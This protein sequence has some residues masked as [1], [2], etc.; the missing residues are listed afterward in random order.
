M[1]IKVITS[2]T[3]IPIDVNFKVSAGPGAGKTHWLIN[4]IKSVLKDSEKLILGRKIA[5]IT[6]TNIGVDTI[7]SRLPFAF[8]KVYIGTI[9]NFFYENVVK[10]YLIFIAKEEGFNIDKLKVIDDELLVSYNL[11]KEI[12]KETKQ[13]YIDPGCFNVAV[14]NCRW[15]LKNNSL[16]FA[17]DRP[18]SATSKFRATLK[19]ENYA[20]YKKKIW[21]RGIMTYDDII[22]FT[23]KLIDRFPFILDILRASYPYFFIDEFQDSTPLQVEILKRISQ[24][25]TVVGIVGDKAQSIYGFAGADPSLLDNFFIGQPSENYKIEG[26]RR[27]T[28]EIVD[29]LNAIRKDLQ[30]FSANHTNAQRPV[31][32]I[33]NRIKAFE[34]AKGS[35]DEGEE[36][37]FLSYRNDTANSMRERYEDKIDNEN[38]LNSIQDGDVRRVNT[39]VAC[40]KAIE[41]A[42]L[43][44]F[45]ESF[46]QMSKMDLTPDESVSV[47]KHFLLDYESFKNQT[48][49]NFIAYI[50]V[51][52][53]KLKVAGLGKG[54]PKVF[55]ND[56][57]YLQLAMEVGTFEKHVLYE[58]IHKAKGDEFDNVFVGIDKIEKGKGKGK[59]LDFLL[60]PNLLNDEEQR[61]YYVAISRAKKRLFIQFPELSDNKIKDL[62]KLP[63]DVIVIK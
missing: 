16:E 15:H 13:T 34:I 38:L 21:S 19:P 63:L 60:Y 47:I 17:P 7:K 8:D 10:H 26:N 12:G 11:I 2:E 27:S 53:A 43:G 14:R 1:A 61:V 9:H 22:Y 56:H 37:Q 3:A 50:N 44:I 51:N 4:H 42:R 54:K 20:I 36:L 18:Y 33:G 41:L 32:Y 49:S 23:Y 40:I 35:L 59:E 29:L 25:N 46:R 52:F 6:Y 55:Y 31:L 58:T 62:K 48:V 57:T 24:E 5:C 30:Q 45:K 28:E 39:I